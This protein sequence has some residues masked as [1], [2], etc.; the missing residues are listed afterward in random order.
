[1][2]VVIAVASTMA[3]LFVSSISAIAS[4]KSSDTN[5]WVISLRLPLASTIHIAAAGRR[6]TAS[7]DSPG[8]TFVG[9][10]FE[11][12][13]RWRFEEGDLLE[14]ELAVAGPRVVI[15]DT[16]RLVAPRTEK[17]RYGVK[18]N[19]YH[20]GLSPQ[21]MRAPI[22]VLCAIDELPPG[23]AEASVDT[24]GW[25]ESPLA[26]VAAQGKLAPDLKSLAQKLTPPGLLFD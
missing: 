13:E 8:A 5:P 22:G 15:P 16:K 4:V 11:G 17:L 2:A 9:R 19:G 25:W 12:G 1:M 20:G 10:K 26:E 14:G 18:K 7:T 21:E 6:T 3:R 23:W 24:P